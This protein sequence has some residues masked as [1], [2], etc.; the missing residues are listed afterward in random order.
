[1]S[2]KKRTV[3]STYLVPAVKALG[4]NKTFRIDYTDDLAQVDP[5]DTITGSTWAIDDAGMTET[6]SSFTDKVTSIRV[7]G[8][9][10]IGN[11]F[12]LTNT[13]TTVGGDT[14]VRLLTVK[15]AN[16]HVK[17]PDE[18]DVEFVEPAPLP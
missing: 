5:A 13:V 2:C 7:S 4:E 1:M 15:I 14:L 8:G 17:R 3:A 6:A 10:R 9:T 12:R 18:E 11:L 16:L